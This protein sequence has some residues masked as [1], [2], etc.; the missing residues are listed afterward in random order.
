MFF[1]YSSLFDD[2]V[3]ILS[4]MVLFPHVIACMFFFPGKTSHQQ[5]TNLN[6]LD[7][8]SVSVFQ[9]FQ[10]THQQNPTGRHWPPWFCGQ[11]QR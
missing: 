7:A 10:V 4:R 11:D 8:N 9:A 1:F 3:L 5:K 6:R 2:H